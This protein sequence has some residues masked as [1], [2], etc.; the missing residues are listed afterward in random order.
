MTEQKT[1]TT[2]PKKTVTATAASVGNEDEWDAEIDSKGMDHAV[3]LAQLY[4]SESEVT[5]IFAICLYRIPDQVTKSHVDWF[6][7]QG[8]DLNASAYRSDGEPTTAL[9][10]VCEYHQ[11]H[12][13]PWLIRSGRCDPNATDTNGFTPIEAALFGHSSSDTLS[14]AEPTLK[15]LVRAGATPVIRLDR[16]VE[17]MDRWLYAVPVLYRDDTKTT[18]AFRVSSWMQVFLLRA[19][20]AAQ[21]QPLNTMNA[22]EESRKKT[23]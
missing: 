10:H 18:R 19:V 12:L 20:L 9:H 13:V 17:I 8:A 15:A 16:A 7:A 3:K 4:P 6:V 5:A 22:T 23:A 21:H 14:D 1:K 2:Q 11:A